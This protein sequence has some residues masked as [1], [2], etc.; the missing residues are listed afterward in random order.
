MDPNNSSYSNKYSGD[1]EAI[2][3][4][5]LMKQKQKQRSSPGHE[6]VNQYPGM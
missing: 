6:M 2:R 3:A 4:I 5:W 1:A